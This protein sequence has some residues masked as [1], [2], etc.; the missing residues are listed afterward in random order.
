MLLQTSSIRFNKLV[1][2]TLSAVTVSLLLAACGGDSGDKTR[3]T[4][5]TAGTG[6]VVTNDGECKP[7]NLTASC[8]CADQ[9]NIPGR[10]V[11]LGGTWSA[12][13]CVAAA[14]GTAGT[15]SSTSDGG[16][17]PPQGTLNDPPGNSS[18]NRFVWKRTPFDIGSCKAGHYVGTFMGFYG[19]PIIF[20]AP[21]PVT[22]TDTPAGPG[23]E[24]TLEKIPGSGELFAI[25]GGK[26]RGNATGVADFTADLTGTLDCAT[27]KYVGTID[28]GEYVVLG[29]AMAKYNFVGTMTAD[30]DKIQHSFINGLWKCTEPPSTTIPPGGDGQWTTTWKP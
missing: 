25:K 20:G 29:N 7:D 14:G 10:Q 28:N 1:A 21:F 24:F 2:G 16:A 18:A 22:A 5:G 26:M 11:C 6:P 8:T 30:Y 15:G 23:L 12:C 4:G 3:I 13:E 27:K 19:S 9:G 17:P